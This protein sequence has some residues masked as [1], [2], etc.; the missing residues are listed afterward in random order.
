[1]WSGALPLSYGPSN[2][3][4]P[5]SKDKEVSDELNG[6]DGLRHKHL[7]VAIE[8]DPQECTGTERPE[9]FNR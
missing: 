2:L 8:T 3:L 5:I 9:V 6:Q 1:M 4:L 7:L